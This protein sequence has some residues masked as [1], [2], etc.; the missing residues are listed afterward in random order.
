MTQKLGGDGDLVFVATVRPCAV[1]DPPFWP[2][3]LAGFAARQIWGYS[4]NSF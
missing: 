3:Q 2:G 1:F 4:D